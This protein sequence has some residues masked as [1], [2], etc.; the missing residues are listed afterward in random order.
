MVD[1]IPV[2]RNHRDRVLFAFYD[3]FD[4]NVSFIQSCVALKPGCTAENGD[5][6]VGSSRR[7]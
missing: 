2:D 4:I 3:V 1:A 5:A 6:V 7:R